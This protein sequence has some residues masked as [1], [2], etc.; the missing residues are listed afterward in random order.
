MKGLIKMA[1]IIIMGMVFDSSDV[2]DFGSIFCSKL[3]G[4]ATFKG[5]NEYGLKSADVE[6]LD[7]ITNAACGSTAFCVDTT[8]IY[9][10]MNT[11]W[12]KV[13]DTGEEQASTLNLS[14]NLTPTFTPSLETINTSQAL[15]LAEITAEITEEI[16]DE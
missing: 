5:V 3:L 1:N 4:G 11:G 8:D 9:V 6:K 13:G 10:L 16:G 2:P 12:E 15:D 14:P 7:L